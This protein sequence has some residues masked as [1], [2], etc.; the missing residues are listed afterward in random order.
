MWGEAKAADG[1]GV[2]VGKADVSCGITADVEGSFCM[3]FVKISKDQSQKGATKASRTR[4]VSVGHEQRRGGAALEIDGACT[5]GRLLCPDVHGRAAGVAK[6]HQPEFD[7][8]SSGNE[9]AILAF[10]T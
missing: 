7:T 2:C 1:E 8:A 6:R 9:M 4:D 3:A 10:G 5:V